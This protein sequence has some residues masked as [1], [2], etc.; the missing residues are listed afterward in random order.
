MSSKRELDDAEEINILIEQNLKNKKKLAE[1]YNQ[2]DPHVQKS[3]IDY[4]FESQTVTNCIFNKAMGRKRRRKSSNSNQPPAKR[5][6]K[7]TISFVLTPA[8][9]PSH[10]LPTDANVSFNIIVQ[11]NTNDN[12]QT[13]TNDN[14]PID[15]D[16]ADADAMEAMEDNHNHNQIFIQPS[17]PITPSTPTSSYQ[18]ESVASLPPLEVDSAVII[19]LTNE[20]GAGED[21]GGRA[22][23][24]DVSNANSGENS[25]SFSENS[26][27]YDQNQH[28]R[29]ASNSNRYESNSVSENLGGSKPSKSNIKQQQ[30]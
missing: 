8:I 24:T 27:G 18:T 26:G 29:A 2:V 23:F 10:I 4:L 13:N 20:T 21:N 30:I 12:V 9:A 16:C 15:K 22:N 17:T 28:Q 3:I 5:R 11:T 19:D 1:K 7:S 14:V 6:R 25:D